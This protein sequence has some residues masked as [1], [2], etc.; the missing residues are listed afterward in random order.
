MK[1]ILLDLCAAIG[2]NLIAFVLGLV[3][4]SV[5]MHID[6]LRNVV[7]VYFF[8]IVFYALLSAI[9]VCIAGLF[10]TNIK[11][12][13]IFF[14]HFDNKLVLSG[15][16]VSFLLMYS[17]LGVTTFTNDRSYTIYSLGYLYENADESFTAEEMEQM[18]IEGFVLRFH[19]T[20]KRIEE[21]I[22]T[23][24]IKEVDGRYSISES[25][26]RFIELQRIIDIFFPT[27]TNPSSLYPYANPNREIIE[28]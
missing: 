27:A 5:L 15:F 24:Y 12:P 18:F 8:R 17:F 22:N 4:C 20:Q 6:F 19:A 16:A 26:K 10:L 1:R 3:F 23:G 25:G 9:I 7:F 2:Y 21:Q 11:E 13:P 28:N 14:K